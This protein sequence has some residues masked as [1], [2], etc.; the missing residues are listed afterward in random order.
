MKRK[1]KLIFTEHSTTNKRRDSVVFKIIDQYVYRRY[2]HVVNISKG[3][4]SSFLNYTK[5]KVKSSIIYNGVN[6]KSLLES[7]KKKSD[8]N[9]VLA[10]KK[11]VLQVSSFNYE[12]D[13]DT[14]IRAIKILPDDYLLLL[15]G[16]GPNFKNCVYLSKKLK[17]SKKVMFLGNRD[18]IGSIIKLSDVCVLSSHVEGFG[19]AAVESMFLKK[20][21]IGSDVEG[22]REVIGDKKLLFKVGDY[23]RLSE[24]I[25]D[26]IENKKYREMII[27]K[28]H[29]KS[30]Q[31]TYTNM[32]KSYENLY[33]S[34]S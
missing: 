8:L 20:P 15:A 22:L 5:N 34:F 11:I 3:S 23:V 16:D 13:Q 18:D 1:P 14:L 32:I 24:L 7:S 29:E 28:S 30:L 6:F 4:H 19:R 31:F 27:K 12:K 33:K 9:K 26:L 17:V 2:D 21:T 25:L 10:E